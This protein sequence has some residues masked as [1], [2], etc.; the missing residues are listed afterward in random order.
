M[1]K[2]ILALLTVCMLLF[3]ATGLVACGGGTKTFTVSFMDDKTVLKTVEVN[4]GE[5]VAKY[6]PEKSGG[7]EFVDWFATPSKNHAFDFNTKITEDI[8]IYAGF[9]LYKEDTRNFYLVGSG[10]SELLFTSNWGKL[11]TDSHKLTKAADKNEYSITCDV[12]KGDQFQF[13]INTDWANKRGFGYLASLNLSDGTAAFSGEGSVYDDSAKG[14]NIKCETAG[15]Y[16]FTLKTYPNED[17]YNTSGQ[18]YT[19]ERKEIYNIGTYDKIEWKRN[20][21]VI[22]SAVTLT[23]YYIKGAQITGWSDIY[24]NATKFAQN[25][26]NYV[27]TVYLKEGDE[28][29]FTSRNTKIEDGKDPAY[30]AGST[31][32]KAENLTEESKQYVD[33]K[34]SGNMVAKANGTYTFTYNGTTLAVAYENKTPAAMDYYLDGNIGASGAWNAFVG[35]PADYKL[36]ETAEGSGIYS[37]TKE[38]AA[39]KEI[40]LRA[41]TAGETPTA[42]NTANNLY[43]YSYLIPHLN[44]EMVSKDNENIKV[45]KAGTYTISFNSYSKTITIVDPNADP[46]DIYVKGGMNGWKHNFDADFRL[47]RS[48][49]DGNVYEGTFEITKDCEFGLEKYSGGAMSGGTF[50]GKDNIGTAGDANEKFVANGNNIKC[51]EEG[52]YKVV[53]NVTDNKVDFYAV[54]AA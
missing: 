1:K 27:L 37:I 51:T 35:A 19:E 20:G 2:R 29:L 24:N 40:Q 4:E 33:G 25:G 38:L 54:T 18:G 7:Y 14:S 46:F 49:T 34:T 9:T 16:T 21:D 41:C 30:S 36:T 10:T 13:V 3:A 17:Y 8:R 11:L 6:I 45:K 28:F 39:G 15:N 22:N 50:V 5:T 26:N 48:T 23:D 44:F 12:K 53:Y 32:I 42:N 43:Q 31:Y 52:T 47:T